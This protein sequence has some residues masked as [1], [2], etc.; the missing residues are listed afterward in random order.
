[1]FRNTLVNYSLAGK[2]LCYSIACY[3]DIAL[4]RQQPTP[5]SAATMSHAVYAANCQ[6]SFRYII[7]HVRLGAMRHTQPHPA[8]LACDAPQLYY[9]RTPKMFAPCTASRKVCTSQ[10]NQA[11][12]TRS[13]QTRS[14]PPNCAANHPAWQLAALQGSWQFTNSIKHAHNSTPPGEAPAGLGLHYH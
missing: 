5:Q 1:M 7:V 9:I 11:T 12:S 13:W 2:Q 8:E 4:V 3:F 14:A 10:I 6:L